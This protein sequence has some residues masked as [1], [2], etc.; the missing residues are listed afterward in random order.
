MTPRRLMMWLFVAAGIPLVAGVFI[1]FIG[2]VG[3]VLSLLIIAVAI[4]DLAISPTPTLVDV[5]REVGDVMSIG[6]RNA[7]KIWFTNRNGGP[8][9]IEFDDEPPAPCDTEGLPF[10]IELPPGRARYRVYHTRPHHRGTNRFGKVYLRSR[11]NLLLWSL[12][13]E[14]EIDSAVRI[15]PDIQ[16]VH[17]MEL[18][19]RRNR[20]SELGLRMS[21][22]MGRGSEFERLREFRREDEYRQIDWKATAKHQ[23][24]ISREYTI[25]R[26]Q[27]ILI[28][29]DAGRSMCNEVDGITHLD[30][31]LNAAIILSYIALRQG[32]YVGLMAFSNK[33]D[34]FVRPMRGA[35][36]V[37]TLIRSV[38]DLEPQY[39]ASDYDLMVEE[40]R[41]RFRKR[42]LVI[43]I[44]H[45]LDELH[46]TT[47]STHMRQ[48]RAPHLVLGAFLRNVPLHERLNTVPE[49]DVEAFQVAAAAE[50][51]SAQTTQIAELQEHGQYAVDS[52]PEDLSADLISQ[53][54]EIKARHLL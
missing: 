1:P 13:H 53:Y 7:V 18:L 25:E 35:G 34:R 2:P 40:V 52:L 30:R 48:L 8:I 32:D 27:N 15:Y 26:N 36:S 46:L 6:A 10:E 24:L 51:V 45:A 50:M 17:A 49:T 22:L 54:L 39:E 41:R 28:L 9:T 47:I 4:A 3:A 42:S 23:K 16:A 14:L 11:S 33:I 21:R 29:L 37:Q 44:S 5:Q 38:Y 31:G 43:L 20:V 12:H 19:A